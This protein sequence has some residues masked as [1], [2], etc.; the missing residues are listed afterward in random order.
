MP[1]AHAS[2]EMIDPVTAAAVRSFAARIHS[3]DVLGVVLFGSRARRSHSPESD[4]D[5]AVLLRGPHGRRIDVALHFADVA[6]DVLQ[7]TGLLIEAVPLWED[8]WAAPETFANPA[9]IANIRRE[10]VR[11]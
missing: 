4:A 7:E 9:L 3:T 11:L 1:V 10:G 6:F 8:E 5:V 2:A